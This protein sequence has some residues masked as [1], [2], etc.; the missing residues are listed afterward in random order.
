MRRR[1]L[2]RSRTQRLRYR[3]GDSIT[4][5]RRPRD[6]LRGCPPPAPPRGYEYPEP[7]P[8]A[9]PS[10]KYRPL[11]GSKQQIRLCRI[12]SQAGEEEIK[13]ILKHFDFN[14]ST[15][16]PYVALS[17]TW[18]EAAPVQTIRLNG[19]LFEVRQNLWNFFVKGT[20]PA[21]EWIWIDH[22]CI[23]QEHILERNAQV[24]L[25]ADIYSRAEEVLV[26]LGE[27]AGN[28]LP[29]MRYLHRNP[30]ASSPDVQSL[31]DGGAGDKTYRR[32]PPRR[33]ELVGLVDLFSRPYWSRLW[34]TQELVRARN[35]VL[36]CGS[37]V[38]DLWS[39]DKL[40]VEHQPLLAYW[41]KALKH[42]DDDDDD[43]EDA[44]KLAKAADGIDFL[45]L[46]RLYANQ[47]VR[48]RDLNPLGPTL[49]RFSQGKC[50]DLRD[51]IFGLQGM[52][53]EDQRVK[54]DYSKPLEDVYVDAVL[55]LSALSRW[56][57]P[58]DGSCHELR[59]LRVDIGF[60]TD[61]VKCFEQRLGL[62]EELP[63]D[64]GEEGEGVYWTWD[65]SPADGELDARWNRIIKSLPWG[66]RARELS[67]TMALLSEIE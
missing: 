10:F 59:N 26:W 38:A 25:M 62:S 45:A 66:E 34:V 46:C 29:I 5:R 20:H 50:D 41:I 13:C 30:S 53:R 67:R 24:D 55:V 15:C 9:P 56:N 61:V 43:D 1:V 44:E 40:M 48:T 8:L 35:V 18:G 6:R 3:V 19:A 37:A 12:E 21:Y 11:D 58:S 64:E 52:V 36:C 31:G 65:T 22:V 28:T 63:E 57:E 14:P 49:S 32:R 33:R 27:G 4:A 2:F 17:Y 51:K 60:G 7:D 39:W 16:P 42:G 23:D 54:I 47:H